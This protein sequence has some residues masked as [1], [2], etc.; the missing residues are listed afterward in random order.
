MA[1]INIANAKPSEDR[2]AAFL[3]NLEL[4][5]NNARCVTDMIYRHVDNGT[6][7]ELLPATIPEGL[8]RVLEAQAEIERLIK[9]FWEELR[10]AAG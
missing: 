8:A 2:I 7:H 9:G 1:T 5:N 10:P 6:S 3:I 4:A